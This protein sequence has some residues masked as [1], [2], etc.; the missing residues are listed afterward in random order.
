M[1]HGDDINLV[2]PVKKHNEEG[3]LLERNAAGSVQIRGV[4]QGRGCSAGKSGQQLIAE[5]SRRRNAS[6]GVP[7]CCLIGL[8]A[9]G[10]VNL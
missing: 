1:G 4:M 6:L 7:Y 3:K 2:L 9:C 10:F 5:P 8:A